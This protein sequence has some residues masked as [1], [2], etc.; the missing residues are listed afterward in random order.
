MG[1]GLMIGQ[2]PQSILCSV[3]D[4]SDF[5]V[6]IHQLTL[7]ECQSLRPVSYFDPQR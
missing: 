6:I 4:L 3:Q 5:I 7:W 2:L 1:P